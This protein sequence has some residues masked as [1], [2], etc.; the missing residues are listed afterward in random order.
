M[1]AIRAARAVR[2]ANIEKKK[3]ER[4]EKFSAENLPG[5]L[6]ARFG[7]ESEEGAWFEGQLSEGASGSEDSEEEEFEL[8]DNEEPE[9]ISES[10][11]DQLLANGRDESAFN[12]TQ[13]LYQRG[14]E[15]SVRTV[16]RIAQKQRADEVAARGTHSIKRFFPSVAPLPTAPPLPKAEQ[17][18]HEL[19]K[20]LADLK[21]K[22]NSKTHG[23][24]E[25][26]LSRHRSVLVFLHLQANKRDDRTRKEMAF[27]VAKCC[28]RG[29]YMA[30]KIIN[31]ERE[32]MDHRNIS[33]GNQGCF[34][35][36]RYKWK[37][38]CLIFV[39]EL[40]TGV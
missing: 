1:Q 6:L 26:T 18:H 38:G 37:T 5:Y 29:Q 35:E 21:R 22:I 13:F 24:N 4:E 30:R 14:P 31:W 28:G 20:A 3:E 8:T 17:R 36:S 15:P 23:L 7:D 27:E 33:V 19:S 25:Q 10:V 39:D 12:S 40:V 34:V 16:R 9:K 2:R 32:W 11:F